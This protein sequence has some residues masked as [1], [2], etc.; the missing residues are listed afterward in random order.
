MDANFRKSLLERMMTIRAFEDTIGKLFYK[1]QI[2]GFIHLSIG[3]EG[4][5]VGSCAALKDTD[6]IGT[7]HRGHGHIIA[8]GVDLNR[9]MAELFGKAGREEPR[10]DVL[11]RRRRKQR[12]DVP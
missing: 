6:Y 1:G 8:K 4:T 11:F 7:T 2:P 5:S 10:G 12:G 9:M 3:Q